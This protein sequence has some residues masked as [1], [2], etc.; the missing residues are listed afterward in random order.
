MR[1]T[2]I[3]AFGEFGLGDFG[4]KS[5]DFGQAAGDFGQGAGDFG[6]QYLYLLWHLCKRFQHLKHKLMNDIL[7]L[8][9]FTNHLRQF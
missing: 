6:L 9:Y 7:F 4:L 2:V 1:C 5:G 3:S 8:F